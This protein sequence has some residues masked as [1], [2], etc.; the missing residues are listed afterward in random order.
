MAL[1]DGAASVWAVATRM[2]VLDVNGFVDPGANT[3]T[4]NALIKATLTPVMETGDDIVVKNAAGD[5]A[6]FAKHSDLIKYYTVAIELATPDPDL[7]QLLAGGVV[8]T[9][10]AAALGTPTGLTVTPQT[11][12]GALAAGTYGY[13]ATVYN[14][15]GESTPQNDVSAAVASG[16]TG[17]NVISGV[18]IPAGALGVRVYG[19]TIGGEQFI[20][21]YPNI[22]TQATSAASGTGSPTSL[23]VTALTAAIPPGT[24]FQIAGDTN[25]TKIVFTTT[26]Y[27]GPGAVSLPVSV[28]QS[29]TTTIAAGN[30]VPVFVDTGAIAPSGN[31]PT[32][33]TTAGPGHVGYQAPAL[34]IVGNPNGVSLEFFSKA[35]V[36][37]YQ[38]P[39]L[40]Y[41]RLVLPRVTGIHQMPRDV[42]NANMANNFEGQGFQNPNWGSGPFGDWQFD[43]TKVFQRARC[44]SQVLPAPGF[45]AVPA[46]V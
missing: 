10:T 16:T 40:P 29:I 2:S 18:T 14:A 15:Y 30:I 25:T 45:A 28:S 43:S 38:S 3:F 31:L 23:A 24:T 34:G 12:L 33:D 6:V 19:R 36:G 42:T 41:Y 22:G 27:A 44:S 46:T 37:G 26:A 8:L 21:S 11:T 32:A 1:P 5:L 35:I 7:E 9:S 13:R 17:L 39:T 20:G 4:S